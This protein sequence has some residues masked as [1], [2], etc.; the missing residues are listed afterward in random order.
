MLGEERLTADTLTLV[1][2][3]DSERLQSAFS[4]IL[5][6]NSVIIKNSDE[7]QIA[8]QNVFDDIGRMGLFSFYCHGWNDKGNLSY[9]ILDDDL[10]ASIWCADDAITSYGSGI[11]RYPLTHLRHSFGNCG[12]CQTKSLIGFN[13]GQSRIGSTLDDRMSGIEVPDTTEYTEEG[14]NDACEDCQEYMS[15]WLAEKVR[16]DPNYLW[17]LGGSGLVHRIPTGYTIPGEFE[18]YDV[19]ELATGSDPPSEIKTDDD[20]I[21]RYEGNRKTLGIDNEGEFLFNSVLSTRLNVD[22]E[23]DEIRLNCKC[24]EPV[25]MSQELDIV[26]CDYEDQRIVVIETTAE[27]EMDTSKL[28][29]KHNV[30][31]QFHAL[32]NQYNDLD[33]QYIYLTTGSYPD[34]LHEDSATLEVQKNI[35]DL[36]ISTEIISRPDSVNQDDLDPNALNHEGSVVFSEK[37]NELYNS[38][39]SECRDRVGKFMT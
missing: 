29:N 38:L 25:K 23:F 36:S 22:F 34:D 33:I 20:F 24:Q 17:G 2:D 32:Q 12:A 27:N 10:V 1:P 16:D 28:R 11:I 31:L 5:L 26:L 39:V 6:E 7:Y 13:L 14:T 37:F 19:L 9:V 18:D 8:E 15:S 30:A 4:V 3:W 21:A 35:S